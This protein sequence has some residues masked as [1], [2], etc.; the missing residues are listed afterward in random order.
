M[1]GDEERHFHA[2]RVRMTSVKCRGREGKPDV[3][4]KLNELDWPEQIK[5]CSTEYS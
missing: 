3:I 5:N 2:G 4:G 1:M